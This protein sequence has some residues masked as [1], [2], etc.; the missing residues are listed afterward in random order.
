MPATITTADQ[1]AVITELE[2]NAPIER[3]FH[4]LTDPAQLMRWWGQEGECKATLWEMDARVG[5]KWRFEA[6]DPSG[7][8]IVNGVSEFRA[9]GEILEF[10]PPRRIAYSW[11]ANWHDRP[12]QP[13]VVTWDLASAGQGTKVRVTHSGLAHLAVAR[14]DYAG[15]WPGVVNYLKTFVER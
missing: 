14:R 6:S 1:D 11:I 5:G 10:S 8:I 7:K 4:A 9:H 13:T 3:V 12:E 2:V 15:G